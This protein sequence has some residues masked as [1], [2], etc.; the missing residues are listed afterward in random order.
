[1][2]VLPLLTHAHAHAHAPAPVPAPV[3]APSADDDAVSVYT[4]MGHVLTTTTDKV[5]E[6]CHGP[7]QIHSCC[8]GRPGTP[9]QARPMCFGV[10]PGAYGTTRVTSTPEA[11]VE[12]TSF[13]A[14]CLAAS[15]WI[16][17]LHLDMIEFLA[18][19]A[20]TNTHTHTINVFTGWVK[21]TLSGIRVTGDSVLGPK[22]AW[23]ACTPCSDG[24]LVHIDTQLVSIPQPVSTDGGTDL[25][26]VVVA[27][28]VPGGAQAP[29][30]RAASTWHKDTRARV[31]R[32]SA[33]RTLNTDTHI[34]QKALEVVTRV[35]TRPLTFGWQLFPDKPPPAASVTSFTPEQGSRAHLSP[36]TNQLCVAVSAA[37][38]LALS[39]ASR[40]EQA[41]A[42]TFSRP[43][44]DTPL[45][46]LSM[47]PCR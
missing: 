19:Q 16:R 28:L 29:V 35:E 2:G 3:P 5:P 10:T 17:Y 12:C 40:S 18:T 22:D 25:Y 47:P 33:D 38:L 36:E 6:V 31:W 41:I 9:A 15:P 34:I 39:T 27:L 45:L 30:Q 21:T 32:R 7:L 26:L 1:M 44:H 43:N 14:S 42:W 13:V 46:Q 4:A 20:F 8:I 23:P 37:T 24:V 11:R